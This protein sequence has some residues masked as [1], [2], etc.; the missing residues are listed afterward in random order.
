FFYNRN[1]RP[2]DAAKQVLRQNQFGGSIGGPIKKDKLFFFGNY[3]GTRQRN[4]VAGEGSSNVF[5]YP[6]PI[7]DRSGSNFPAALGA[8]LCPPNH[9]GD[10]RYMTGVAAGGAPAFVAGMNG[11]ACDGSNVSPVALNLLRVKNADGSYYIPSSGTS[12]IRNV[13]CSA[14]AKYTDNQYIG[15]VDWL[16]SPRHTVAGRFFYTRN[17][18]EQ[19]VGG[20]P[21]GQLPG[22]NN[23]QFYS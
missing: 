13:T 1:R 23:H 2:V 20:V 22:W 11:V 5:L 10:A 12:D 18:R 7:G 8:A 15:N 17:P 14:P 6:V 3:Q 16:A 9:P 21:V 4:G 19:T